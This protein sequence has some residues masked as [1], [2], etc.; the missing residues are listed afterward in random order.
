MSG[1]FLKGKVYQPILADIR[2]NLSLSLLLLFLSSPP[3]SAL[4]RILIDDRSRYDSRSKGHDTVLWS[5]YGKRM[6]TQLILLCSPFTCLV[7]LII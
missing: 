5:N 4:L 6:E 2:T 1:E 3:L 7:I